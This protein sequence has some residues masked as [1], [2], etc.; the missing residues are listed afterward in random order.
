MK[1]RR[2]TI[3]LRNGAAVLA[4]K[5][6]LDT[7]DLDGSSE[8]VAV[9]MSKDLTRLHSAYDTYRKAVPGAPELAKIVDSR[10]GVPEDYNHLLENKVIKDPQERVEPP[11]KP[12]GQ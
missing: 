6:A 4:W 5:H 1:P 10:P 2:Q 7:D 9:V 8:D 3:K 12:S 11:R